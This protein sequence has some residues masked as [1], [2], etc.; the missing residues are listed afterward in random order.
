MIT[1]KPLITPCVIEKRKYIEEAVALAALIAKEK[2]IEVGLFTEGSLKPFAAVNQ[3]A[4]DII[5]SKH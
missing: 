4:W 3:L 5:Y 2:R 1:I